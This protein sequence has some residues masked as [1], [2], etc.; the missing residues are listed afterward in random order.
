[1]HVL[2]FLQ[3]IRKIY[4]KQKPDLDKIEQ[5]GLLA[6][7][8][9]QHFALR[10]D[11]LDE[12]VCRHLMQLYGHASKLDAEASRT[13][14]D[15]VMPPG[16]QERFSSITYEPFTAASVGQVHDAVLDNGDRVIIKLIKH[17]YLDAFLRDLRGLTRFFRV[18]IFFYPRLSRV[19]DPI[20]ILDYI[21]AYT[22]KEL[23]LRDEYNGQ[24]QL[25]RIAEAH[26]HEYDLSRLRFH[27]IYEDLCGERYLVSHRIEGTTLDDLISA[28]KVTYD[29]LLEL[30]K[31]H[32]FYLFAIG[33]FHGDI[34]PANVM[35]DREGYFYFVDT[36][37]ISEVSTRMRYGLFHF[38]ESL[39]VFDYPTSAERINEMATEGIDGNAYAKFRQQFLTLYR[40]FTESTVSEVS[41]TKKMMQ[42][43][44]LA[45]NCGMRFE[46]GMFAIIKSLM[47]L[48]GMVL[49]VNPNAVLL[50][51]MRPFIENFKK[52][53][54]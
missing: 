49:R 1:V 9:A 12:E 46:R 32:G 21:A 47:Y 26:A 28:Q 31:I 2:G 40:D 37:A 17:D 30:F 8:I 33:T 27:T 10:I 19:F 44:K 29:T 36:G 35:M 51:D 14:L 22:R 48:D 34:H 50:K 4:G 11:F 42:T 52:V 53:M 13:L 54:H 43:I 23:N 25:K 18:V 39:C 6:V 24:Q 15:E 41:L 45:V 20:G 3:L 38:F 5:Q 16:W 7:K